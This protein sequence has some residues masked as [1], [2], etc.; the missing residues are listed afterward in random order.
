VSLATLYVQEERLRAEALKLVEADDSLIIHIRSIEE[1]MNLAY[2]LR[3]YNTDSEDLKL[4][5]LLGMRTFNAF[6]TSLKLALSGYF[7]NSALIMRDILE[8]AFLLDYFGSYPE[9]ISIW[10]NSDKKARLKDFRPV[11]IREALDRRDGYDN[12]KRA[13][14][15]EM[16]SELAGHPTMSSVAM[17]R[18]KTSGDIYIG[19]FIENGILKETL[20]EMGRLAVQIG[21]SLYSFFPQDAGFGHDDKVAFLKAKAEWINKFYPKLAQ[22]C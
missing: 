17:M 12:K 3:D 11:K 5:Q 1:A 4:I 19:P 14:L 21:E 20:D 10:R 13:Y 6:A 8:T 7:Q 2:V 22:K 16:F 18:P 9:K 15:Y